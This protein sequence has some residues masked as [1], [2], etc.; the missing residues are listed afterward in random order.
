MNLTKREQDLLKYWDREFDEG[1]TQ[2]RYDICE[3]LM[4]IIRRLM[5]YVKSPKA[6]AHCYLCEG[7]GCSLCED[8]RSYPAR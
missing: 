6:F 4:A 1:G 5:R 7:M 3:E 2:E 8:D